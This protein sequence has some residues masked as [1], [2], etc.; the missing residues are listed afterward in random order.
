MAQFLRTTLVPDEAQSADGQVKYDLPVN[1]ISHIL[2]TLK[3]LNDTGTLTA[4]S[5]LLGLLSMVTEI[6]VQYRGATVWQGS[7]T[8]LY[9]AQSLIHGWAPWGGNWDPTNDDVRW[10]TVP[11]VFGRRPFLMDEC[12][13]ATRRGDLTMTLTYD[14][15]VT[16][17]NTLIAQVE[18]VELL[19]AQPAR[20]LKYSTTEKI[21]NA[22]GTH[23][24]DL[25]IGNPILGVLLNSP[26]VPDEA[27]YLS[28]FGQVALQVD[29]VEVFY[30]G[31][32][33]ESLQGEFARRLPSGLLMAS[34]VHQA[35]GGA[36]AYEATT[37]PYLGARTLEQYAFLDFDPLGDGNFALQTSGAARVNLQ[38]TS[39]EASATAGRYMPI[40]V[41]EVGGT[42]GAA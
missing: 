8:D 21:F 22:T 37:Q 15:A 6:R 28:A 40:E 10:L 17:L 35:N 26:A 24:V 42:A 12:F 18:T 11:L 41:V 4:F 29:N 34:H 27:D 2:L 19:D 20:F 32:N 25:P 36:A 30:S 38:I 5:T 31:A 9:L 33:W 39:E 3:A 23:Q 7:L 13:P 16:G 14:V 1:P